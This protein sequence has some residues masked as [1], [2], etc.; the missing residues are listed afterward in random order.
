VRNG[1]F[2]VAIWLSFIA[3]SLATAPIPGPNEPHYLCKARQLIDPTW[4][5]GDF[6]L[7][8]T[9][10]HAVFFWVFGL[11]TQ[12][13][14]LDATAACCRLVSLAIVAIGW[15]ATFGQLTR[16]Y[17]QPLV[18]AWTYLA[19]TV[20]GN[21]SGEWLVGGGEAKVF[22]YGL[23][24]IAFA[25]WAMGLTMT[26]AAI[27]GL[28]VAWH[29]VVGAWGVLAWLAGH[30]FTTP[31]PLSTRARVLIVTK[32][33]GMLT[34]FSLPG[35]VPAIWLLAAP[36]EPQTRFAGT[37]IQVYFR[38]AHH[39]DPM[40]FTRW[41]WIYYGLL[42][43]AAIVVWRLRSKL[44][45]DERTGADVAQHPA[46]S[47]ARQWLAMLVAAFVIAGVGLILGLGPRP[48]PLMWG[49]AWRQELLKFYP[50]RLFDL[51]LPV[52]TA[53]LLVRLVA[54]SDW[55]ILTRSPR[56]RQSLFLLS[57]LLPLGL[58]VLGRRTLP[59][60]RLD[61][62]RWVAWKDVCKIAK[63]VLPANAVVQTPHASFGFKWFGERA[64]YINFK[65][66]PQDAAGIVEW[67]R[68]LKFLHTWYQ[69][70]YADQLYDA[71]ELTRLRQETGITH[72]ITDR[73]GPFEAVML[74]ENPVYRLI[75]LPLSPRVEKRLQND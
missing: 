2:A 28:G 47:F 36:G 32:H 34:L 52:T 16:S 11:V 73:L 10:A 43:L 30:Y 42:S 59:D 14:L 71:A 23:L 40:V 74:Y 72:V 56:F 3:W 13:L 1:A 46:D 7:E 26:S 12:V 49:Y 67:N 15:Q 33:L 35:L 68:R 50:F 17:W 6:F 66:C 55:G 58:L 51:M 5:P 24:L 4:I 38:L 9:S 18:I 37:F 27:A 65:D 70:Q 60:G 62:E 48:A 53:W 69:D 63:D 44:T 64:E 39:L 8:S 54:A 61:H 31:P 45:H 57:I 22:A 21:L 20:G 25:V 19:L 75:E 41:S 29:P